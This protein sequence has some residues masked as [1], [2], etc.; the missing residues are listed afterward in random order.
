[1]YTGHAMSSP[2]ARRPARVPVRLQ[3]E[4]RAV[5]RVETVW[6]TVVNLSAAGMLVELGFPL[7]PGTD[8]DFTF[9]LPGE[10]SP[11][12]GWGQIVRRATPSRYGVRFDGLKDDAIERLRRNQSKREEN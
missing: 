3:L 5:S 6:G 12:T 7:A 11:V 1:M 8:L 9:L 4:G 2:I 10:D